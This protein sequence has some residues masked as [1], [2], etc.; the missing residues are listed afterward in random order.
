MCI[1]TSLF[2]N[3]KKQKQRQPA[4]FLERLEGLGFGNVHGSHYTAKRGAMRMF[5]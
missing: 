5:G 3:L 4:S 2:F 1:Q